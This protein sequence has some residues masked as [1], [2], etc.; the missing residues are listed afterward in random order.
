[1]TDAARL[2]EAAAQWA[3]SRRVPVRGV[4]LRY[5]EAGEGP[6]V[7]LAHGLGCSAD[8]W[9]RN[10]PPLA[11]AGYRV[12]APDLPGYGRTEG[13][14]RG[15]SIPRQAAWL[16]GFADALDL[17]AAVYVGHSISCGSVLE[18]AA[19]RPARVAGLVLAAP[20]DNDRRL[21]EMVGLLR[22]LPRE[23]LSLVPWI[24]DA[25]LR[26]GV[27]RW[28]GSWWAAKQHRLLDAAR[29]ARCDSLVIVGDRD[30][31][32]PGPWAESVAAALGG[33]YTVISG[34][35]ALIYDAAPAFNQAVLEFVGC[36][37]GASGE[38]EVAPSPERRTG[39]G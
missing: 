14:W 32:V 30:P 2:G 34:A 20:T 7:V 16:G 24:A 17:P 13:P 18:L 33:R 8:Y 10:G 28:L 3:V 19:T 26:A 6:V 21:R 25:Y 9:M 12:L 23:P 15:M 5:H 27:V 22:D 31:V 11:A 39:A 29:R 1:V 36:I 35:H 38:H 37:D 4:A